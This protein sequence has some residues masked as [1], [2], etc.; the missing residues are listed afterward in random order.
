MEIRNALA[1]LFGRA[2]EPSRASS[3]KELGGYTAHFTPFSGDVYANELSRACVRTLAEQT[4]KANAKTGDQRLERLLRY[5][6]NLFMNGKDFLYK[7]RTILEVNNT[8]FIYLQR[9]ERGRT[10]GL[11][12]MPPTGME[13][14]EFGGELYVK[15]NYAT[16][17]MVLP[18]AD[19][20]VLRK[21]YYKSDLFGEHNAAIHQALDTLHTAN[22]GVGNAIKATANLRGILKTTKSMLKDDDLKKI[23]DNFVRDFVALENTS[24]IAAIDATTD[25]VPV[26]LSPTVVTAKTMEELKN[27]IYRYFGVNEDA[28]MGKLHGEA[29]EAFYDAQIEPFLIALGLELSYK[30]FTER[31]RGFGNEIVFESNRM[32]YMSNS[33]KMAMVALVDRSIM[34]PNELR[35]IMNMEP[36]DGGDVPL[37][38]LD[39]APVGMV[40]EEEPAEEESDDNEG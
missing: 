40:P 3:L 2:R 21:D 29:W 17:T 25:Y 31:E 7:V 22:E 10:I 14:V 13:G 26:N 1:A 23:K 24:G 9:D 38:R 5:R 28:V 37:L 36:I 32:M 11:Y 20:A 27:N 35:A 19:L 39:T 33:A 34:T 12:P 6:P 4:S 15:F 18:W 30:I 16:R 8:A